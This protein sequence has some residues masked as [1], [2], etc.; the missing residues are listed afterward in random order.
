MKIYNAKPVILA[1]VHPIHNNYIVSCGND[2]SIRCMGSAA[3]AAVANYGD[4][5]LR[6]RLFDARRMRSKADTLVCA[7]HERVVNSAYWSPHTGKMMA[8]HAS[9][10]A[11]DV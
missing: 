2:K 1:G 11:C 7:Q 5:T 6:P 3:A 4:V 8:C 10:A 9:L